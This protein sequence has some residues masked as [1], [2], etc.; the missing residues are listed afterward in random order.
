MYVYACMA[1]YR[2]T[3]TYRYKLYVAIENSHATLLS[4]VPH[5]CWHG[6]EIHANTVHTLLLYFLITV[7][8]IPLLTNFLIKETC[9]IMTF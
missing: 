6:H 2:Y 3:Y 7:I 1:M 5:V 9:I 4:S 8:A